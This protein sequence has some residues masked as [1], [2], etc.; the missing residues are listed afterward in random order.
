V[1]LWRK[2]MRP[3]YSGLHI[4]GMLTGAAALMAAALQHPRRPARSGAKASTLRCVYEAREQNDDIALYKE[5]H[6]T[7]L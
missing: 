4:L 6:R 2:R 1:K 7:E 5:S 3:I